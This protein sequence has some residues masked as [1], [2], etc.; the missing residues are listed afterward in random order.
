MHIAVVTTELAT[1]V[2]SSGGLASFT[3]N[4]ARIFRQE[5][6]EVSIILVT[7]KE[8]RLAFDEGILLENVY[9][10]KAL[11]DKF[12]STAQIMAAVLEKDPDELRK[13]AVNL[14]KSERV[15]E[16]IHRIDQKRKIDIIHVCNLCALSVRLDGRIP[17]VVRMSCIESIWDAADMPDTCTGCMGNVLSVKNRFQNYM[18]QNTRYIVS[19]SNLVAE[20]V[21]EIT[22]T[23]PVVIESPFMINKKKWDYSV[24]RSLCSDKK[25]IIH[26]GTLSY[27]KGTHIVAQIIEPLLEACPDISMVL[28]GNSTDMMDAGGK[29]IKAHELVKHNAGRYADR[30]IYAGRPVREQLYPLIVGAELCLLPS[31]V[32]NLSN[33][34]IEAMAL[35]K[36]VVGTEGASFEQLIRN[37]V[38]GFL[39]E[40]DNPDS[41]LQA[42]HEVLE[43]NS[44]G[45]SRMMVNA[46]ERIKELAPDKIYSKYLAFYERVIREWER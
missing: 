36:I 33:A 25:Y 5:G 12:D 45:R 29:R 42:V 40:K 7:T 46:K 37:R 11:W 19:P 27:R 24:F 8:E 30:V 2:H 38:S 44:Q 32:E 21:K 16:V 23:E 34:G 20:T 26:Y 9:V 15:N 6:H 43:M 39:C 35:G 13:L 3:A 10:E 28:A 22:G 31:R 17:Y 4:L 1:E 18:L 41:F 14:Y